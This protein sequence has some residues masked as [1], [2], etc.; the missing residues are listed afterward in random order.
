MS[1]NYNFDRVEMVLT[2]IKIVLIILVVGLIGWLVVSCEREVY[3]EKATIVSSN[4]GMIEQMDP[5]Y[6]DD[7]DVEIF[8]KKSGDPIV[9][10]YEIEADDLG[11]FVGMDLKEGAKV[12]VEVSKTWIGKDDSNASYDWTWRDGINAG[13]SYDAD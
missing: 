12:N 11:R 13:A 1:K 4:I 9:Q 7:E 6:I 10:E 8:I 5:R 3:T 2:A